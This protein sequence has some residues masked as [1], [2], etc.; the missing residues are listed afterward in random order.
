ME[1]L[2]I[3]IIVLLNGLVDR[4]ATCRLLIQFTSFLDY[5]IWFQ[6]LDVL[7]NRPGLAIRDEELLAIFRDLYSGVKLIMVHHCAIERVVVLL[8]VDRLLLHLLKQIRIRV[9]SISFIKLVLLNIVLVLDSVLL[10]KVNLLLPRAI[11]IF[12]MVQVIKFQLNVF[13]LLAMSIECL[14]NAFVIF[15]EEIIIGLHINDWRF[16]LLLLRMRHRCLFQLVGVIEE[17]DVATVACEV[18]SAN[19]LASSTCFLRRLQIIVLF[20]IWRVTALSKFLWYFVFSYVVLL[21]LLAVHT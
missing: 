16:V 14:V 7:L 12:V 21:A 3:L 1:T 11:V 19:V 13:K 2:V 10:Q 17:V 9:L 20:K 18:S 15:V 6:L 5:F 4:L 8:A